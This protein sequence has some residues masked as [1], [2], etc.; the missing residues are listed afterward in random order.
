MILKNKVLV[1]IFVPSVEKVYS[2]W[3]PAN[4]KIGNIIILL[5]KVICELNG[6]INVINNNC[7]MY[8][9]INGKKYGPNET[10]R[11]TDIRNGTKLVII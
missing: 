4:K 2:V 9:R 11:D 3:L 1:E 6:S 8:N 5:T 10:L 7:C